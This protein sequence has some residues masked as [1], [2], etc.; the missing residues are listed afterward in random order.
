M[1]DVSRIDWLPD[2]MPGKL[3][4]GLQ[5]HNLI[6]PPGLIEVQTVLDVGAGIRPMSWYKP[7]RHI[8]VEPHPPYAERLMAAGFEVINKTADEALD[9]E[10]A[11]AIYLLDVIEHMEKEDGLRIINKMLNAARTQ[12]VIYTPFGFLEQDHDPWE[13]GGDYWQLHR[14]GWLPEEF[15]GWVTQRYARGFFAVMNL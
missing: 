15:P 7:R 5:A 3:P 13:L 4:H 11:D 6:R 9:T 8:C 12:V 14:S 2:W 1:S 10:T